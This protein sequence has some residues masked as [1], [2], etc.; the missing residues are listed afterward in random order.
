MMIRRCLQQ[1]FR[2][3]RVTIP[4]LVILCLLVAFLSMGLDLMSSGVQM[5]AKAEDAFDTIGVVEFFRDVPTDPDYYVMQAELDHG[6]LSEETYQAH[7]NPEQRNDNMYR[8]ALKDGKLQYTGETVSRGVQRRGFDLSAITSSPYVMQAETRARYGAHIDGLKQNRDLIEH[9]ARETDL[10]VFTPQLT[11]AFTYD[12]GTG[13]AEVTLP[14][15]IEYSLQAELLGSDAI[16]ELTTL[17]I[18]PSSSL[19]LEPGKTYAAICQYNLDPRYIGNAEL[20]LELCIRMPQNIVGDYIQYFADD[21]KDS[22]SP[23]YDRNGSLLCEYHDGFFDTPEGARMKRIAQATETTAESA[24]VMTSDDLLL[25][26]PFHNNTLNIREGR[27]FTDDEYAGGEQVC[28][29]S[30]EMAQANGWQVGDTIPMELYGYDAFTAYDVDI[31]FGNTG[32]YSPVFF[33]DQ[34]NIFSR[35]TYRIVGLYDGGNLY[36]GKDLVVVHGEETGDEK[37]NAAQSRYVLSSSVIFVPTASVQ[38]APADA[39]A[40][41]LTT[42]FRIKNGVVDLFL[43]E[44]QQKG[45]QERSVDGYTCEFTFYDQGYYRVSGLLESTRQLA[46]VLVT[47]SLVTALECMLL[48]SYLYILRRKKEISVMRSMGMGRWA[49]ASGMLFGIVLITLGGIAGGCLL[50]YAALGAAGSR[51][52][53]DPGDQISSMFSNLFGQ[54]IDKSAMFTL[55]RAPGSFA[56][57]AGIVLGLSVVTVSLFLILT[58]A[59][60]PMKL[61]SGRKE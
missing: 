24:V 50:G 42:S 51:I 54:D 16:Y 31:G 49:I 19:L 39:P 60:S 25:F 4:Y 13:S 32:N 53:S 22:T 15:Q 18:I 35:Q 47:V 45:L 14:V 28:L 37:T 41:Y 56:A 20:G 27:S 7:Y 10:L 6:T 30:Y 61:L 57:A 58:L 40:S 36:D 2:K 48:F 17:K 44:M 9:A 33:A 23:L 8:F 5:A 29:L 59:Q 11:E 12:P 43:D 3:P 38:N 1:M 46:N 26:M 55:S 52:L 21:E 34:S